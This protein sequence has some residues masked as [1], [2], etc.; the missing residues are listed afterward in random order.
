MSMESQVE[1]RRLVRVAD[2]PT[3]S[4]LITSAGDLAKLDAGLGLLEPPCRARGWQ[5]VVV[6]SG[7]GSVGWQLKTRY[8]S[9]QFLNAPAGTTVAD[10]RVIG[11]AAADGDIVIFGE[12]HQV[13]P[14]WIASSVFSNEPNATQKS[15]Y[16]GAVE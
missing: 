7:D 2:S 6:R 11:M 9:V 12:D 3:V 4:V 10:M 16:E 13:T 15:E 14:D 5:L 8:T 1:I